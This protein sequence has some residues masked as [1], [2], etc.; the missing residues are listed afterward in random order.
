MK[1]YKI[2]EGSIADFVMKKR[3]AIAVLATASLIMGM[4]TV[5]QMAFTNKEP[6][7]TTDTPTEV[8]T[9]EQTK[10]VQK[11]TTWDVP[12]SADLQAYIVDQCE[13]SDVP[14]EIVIAVIEQESNYNQSAIGDHG[15]SFGLMQVQ[16]WC[17]ESRMQRLGCTDLFDP[18]QNVTVGIDILAEK[19]S[20][21]ATVGEALTAYNA[22]AGGAYKH[23]FS[24]GIY[25]NEYAESVIKLANELERR[26]RDD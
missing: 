22:G 7:M 3:K 8:E 14:P 13:E 16:K 10:P 1:K 6:T 15:K 5:A 17:H 2:R 18:Y 24:K 12:L 20:K 4:F 21:Y 11:T 25:A 19:L 9:Q 23:Y 26:T